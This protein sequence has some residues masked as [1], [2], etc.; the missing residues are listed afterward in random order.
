MFNKLAGLLRKSDYVAGIDLGTS[1]VKLVV[2]QI[3]G[4]KPV[5]LFA[6]TIDYTEHVASVREVIEDVSFARVMEL[7]GVTC[8]RRL[9]RFLS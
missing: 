2:C 5:L 3:K 1:A 8:Q 7:C 6:T 9:K 4:S